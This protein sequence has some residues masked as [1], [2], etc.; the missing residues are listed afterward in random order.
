M[1]LVVHR[2]EVAQP[3]R[4]QAVGTEHVRH[5][6]ELIQAFFPDCP[7]IGIQL[8]WIWHTEDGDVVRGCGI[9]APS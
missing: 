8:F 3:L 4:F 9:L 2:H 1:N 6:A 7:Q 5:E